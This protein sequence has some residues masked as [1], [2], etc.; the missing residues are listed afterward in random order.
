[1]MRLFGSKACS[2]RGLDLDPVGNWR[3]WYEQG[4]TLADA[5]CYPEALASFDQS[6]NLHPDSAMTWVFRGVVLIHL[7]RYAEAL[8][9]CD[10]ALKLHPGDREAWLFRGVALH[11][12]NHHK[13]AYTCYQKALG[14][15][16]LAKSMRTPHSFLQKLQKL[17]GQW[18]SLWL[19]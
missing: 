11:Y 8:Q 4:E 1:M 9:S 13:D 18:R 10:R 16:V 14:A 6:L 5:G 17:S 2:V 7:C 12:L 3:D 15:S 19:G